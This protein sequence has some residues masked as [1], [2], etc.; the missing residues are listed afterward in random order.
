M[1]I[2]TLS[3]ESSHF[4]VM[5]NEIIEISSPA[6]GGHF[7]D[8]TFGGGGYSK[9]LLQ[10][11]KTKVIGIDR[12]QTVATIA[13]KILKKFK[14]RFQFY[15]LKFSQI[16]T[17]SKNCVV[18]LVNRKPMMKSTSPTGSHVVVKLSKL[19]RIGI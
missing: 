15:Q 17:I 18:E 2:Q 1:K 6:K 9:A 19:S 14:N 10:F 5:L 16:D 3:L 7:I 12:D 4:P 11:P 13:A 8:S